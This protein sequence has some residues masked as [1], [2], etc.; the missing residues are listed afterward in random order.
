M[1]LTI[2]KPK[3]PEEAHPCTCELALPLSRQQASKTGTVSAHLDVEGEFVLRKYTLN[4]ATGQQQACN[5]SQRQKATG[6]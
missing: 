1:P 5:A 6:E 4:R 3:E 2:S